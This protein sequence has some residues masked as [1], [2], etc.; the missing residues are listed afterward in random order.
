MDDKKNLFRK[1]ALKSKSV[2]LAGRVV[3]TSPL[4]LTIM[5]YFFVF[6]VLL[7]IIFI[8]FSEYPRKTSVKGQVYPKEGMFKVYASDTGVISDIKVRDGQFVN[9]GDVLG[10]IYKAQSL[11]EST[12][13]DKLK[14]KVLLK[15][16]TIIQ[17][18]IKL[19]KIQMNKL[20]LLNSDI[21][22]LISQRGYI[23]EQISL[24]EK[25]LNKLKDNIVKYKV[26]N[27]K[28]YVSDEDINI[29]ENNELEQ[30]IQLNS[31]KKELTII[32]RLISEKKIEISDFPL[33]KIIESQEFERTLVSIE[34]ELLH[35]ESQTESIIRAYTSGFV[36]MN[37][38]ELGLQ[39]N[40]SILLL[41]INTKNQNLILH[42][43]I[44]SQSMGFVK[45]GDLVN[46]RYSAY[47]YQKFGV[48]KARIV[49]ISKSAIPIHEVKSIGTVLPALNIT[50][51]P[52]YL[53]KAE[54]E[55]KYMEVNGVKKPLDIGMI[56]DADILHEKRKLYEWMFEPLFAITKKS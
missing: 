30:V 38:F 11:N 24:Q 53:I 22:N 54:P 37:N 41:S 39:V 51:E 23:N 52:I 21:S 32:D 33:K 25:K 28:G 16:K 43:Y 6:F 5:T 40:Q 31:S 29:A 45:N 36:S 47:P 9:K 18:M 8:I 10:V 20:E 46:I 13:Q 50:N 12:L 44:P 15:K 1:E 26:L 2:S 14:E 56:F 4:L 3:L 7:S 49:S 55:K 35:I 27:K 48:F 17:E 19:E 42:L 34:Q